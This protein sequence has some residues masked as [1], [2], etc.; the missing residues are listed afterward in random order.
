[1]RIAH[2]GSNIAGVPLTL[3][4]AQRAAGHQATAI[5]Y[6]TARGAQA[7]AVD[8]DRLLQGSRVGRKARRARVAAWLATG[9]DLLH[10]H[11]HTTLD[12]A[13][14][15][16]AL[17]KALGR[18][19]V[20]HLH[21][22]D[23]R[24]PR[25]VRLEHA[26]SACATCP[27]QCLTKVK[28][29]L[30]DALVRHADKVVVATPDLLEFVPDAEL[31]PNPIDLSLWQRLRADAPSPHHGTRPWVIVHAPTDRAIKGTAHVE[32]AV[33]RLQAE[34][35]AVE[36]RLLEGLAP[37]ELRRACLEADIAVDQV[38][39]GWIGLFAA[40]MMALGKP[41]V[42]YIRPDLLANQPGLPVASASP[43]QLADCL[44]ALIESPSARADLAERGPAWVAAHHDP[45]DIAARML[46]LYALLGVG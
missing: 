23:I 35:L 17:Y 39:I 38:L 41:V 40:E 16:L 42:A 44:R 13:H 10:F 36:L 11:F 45:T 8:L 30:P 1:M 28:L 22:C 27:V 15:D 31:I 25:R 34:G 12:P 3:T 43:D 24:D 19:I 2:V 7:G 21:G 33:A 29:T 9:F 5:L 37:A 20:F 46:E 18:R 14:R 4:R 26:V 32:A 6:R